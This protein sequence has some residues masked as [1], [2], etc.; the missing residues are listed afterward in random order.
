MKKI[1]IIFL[2]IIFGSSF[3]LAKDNKKIT[4]KEIEKIFF[5]KKKIIHSPEFN[6][7]LL[8]VGESNVEKY[9][10]INFQIILKKMT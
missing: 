3:S 5:G 6:F 2:L 4:V 10:L 7:K 1:F 9:L 8:I